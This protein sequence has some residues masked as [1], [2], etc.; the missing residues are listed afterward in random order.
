MEFETLLSENTNVVEIYICPTTVVFDGKFTVQVGWHEPIV[1]GTG[2]GSPTV[3]EIK[4][5]YHRDLVYTYDIAND[6]QRAFRRLVQN[7]RASGNMCFME[8]TI[9][10]HRFPC[11]KDIAHETTIVRRS[12]RVNNRM[13]FIHDRDPEQNN[14]YYLRYQHS[15]NVDIKKMNLDFQKICG[16][17]RKI[18]MLG[19]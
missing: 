5:Y 1:L 13:F 2:I 9:P 3:Q 15:D 7:E 4:E 8:E 12:Y 19:R 11:T 18:K 10:S 6:G 16:Y 17:L 14:Y